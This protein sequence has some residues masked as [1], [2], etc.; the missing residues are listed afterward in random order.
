MERKYYKILLKE[1]YGDI[2][3]DRCQIR[4]LILNKFKRIDQLILPLKSSE[5]IWFFD[6]FRREWA[7]NFRIISL[8][9]FVSNA[10]LL[11]PLK[12]C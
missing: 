12:A 8:N 9:L 4:F 11:Y 1:I 2:V 3:T 7:F 6:S 10:P 5:N